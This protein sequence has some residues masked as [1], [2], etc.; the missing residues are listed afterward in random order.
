MLVERCF[1]ALDQEQ[2]RFQDPEGRCAVAS[3]GA[4]AVGIGVCILV[5]PELVVGA[6]IITGVVVVGVAIK[7]AL[8]AYALQGSNSEDSRP[9]P[10]T[11]AAPREPVA[12]RRPRTG[13]SGQGWPPH[14]PPELR[15][16][17]RKLDCT[18]R[19]VPH[20][21]GDAL[22]NR[23]ADRVPQN[24]FPGSD[25]L[26]NGKNFDAL[27]LATR[28]LWEIKTDDFDKQSPHSQ[29]FFARMKLPEIQSEKRL[30]EACGYDF[31]VGVRSA[32]H[33]A[34]LLDL[35]PELKVVVMDWC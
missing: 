8:D 14:V 16:R 31:V 20:L 30:A 27:Q 1:H 17:E 32:A 5:A 33:R 22:H 21:G 28:T 2:V 25:V 35:D 18:P 13:S 10:E 9:V 24:H 29:R 11:E 26:V 19:P 34:A 3:A 12:E 15:D 7:H 6:V 23:C 4:A